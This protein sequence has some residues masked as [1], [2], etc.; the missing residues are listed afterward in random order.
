MASMRRRSALNK[1]CNYRPRAPEMERQAMRISLRRGALGKAQPNKGRSM[2]LKS[3]GRLLI[4]ELQEVYISET[5]IQEALGRLETGASAKE[6]KGAFEKHGE[7]TGAQIARLETVFEKLEASPRGGHGYSMKALLRETEDRMGDGG[8][9][10]VVD[11][12]LI[13]A[14]RRMVH[15]K[16]AAYGTTQIY[17]E[18]LQLGDVA[19]MLGQ[20][21]EEEIAAD[22]RLAELA[23]QI[24]VL[25]NDEV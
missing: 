20:T 23:K 22:A 3:L 24:D 10:P 6:L 4:D 16:I 19:K 14:A 25:G 7:Q 13:G 21:L 18:R 17:A 11:A 5:L 8:D 9:A 15:W 1:C 2:Q 12:S